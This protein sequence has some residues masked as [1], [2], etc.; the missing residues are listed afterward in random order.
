MVSE[1]AIEKFEANPVNEEGLKLQE[2]F[3]TKKTVDKVLSLL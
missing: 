1:K 2:E 3:T